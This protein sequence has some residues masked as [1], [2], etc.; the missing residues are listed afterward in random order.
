MGMTPDLLA[1]FHEHIRIDGDC[2]VWTGYVSGKEHKVPQLTIGK[3]KFN[4]RRLLYEHE[5]G[6][7]GAKQLG[8]LCGNP[9]CVNPAHWKVR[10]KNPAGN[11]EYCRRY[12]ERNGQR[13]RTTPI[14]QTSSPQQ[15]SLQQ[16]SLQRVRAL[17]SRFGLQM[18]EIG[19]H[20][21]KM[22]RG[23]E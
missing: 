7:L 4:P 9:L 10:E 23:L 8:N 13:A 19:D 11:A 12:R 2:W 17:A 18:I 21:W 16:T 5:H 22:K 14:Q 1:R 3:Q 6:P 20:R 15:T